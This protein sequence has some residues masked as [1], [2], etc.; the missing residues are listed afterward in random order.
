M[1]I[2]HRTATL[3]DAAALLNWR[4]NSSVREFSM[5]S[6]TIPMDEHLKWLTERLERV[7]LEPFLLFTKDDNLIGM[8]RLD[9]VS[10][11]NFKNEISV[12]VDSSQHG[13]R[14]GTKILKVTCDIF[15][16]LYPNKTIVAKVHR[17]NFVSQKLFARGGFRFISPEGEFLHFEKDLNQC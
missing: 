1:E 3:G 15:F 10:G 11:S 9:V 13:K 2:T 8:S 7:Q 5:N 4:N 6:K 14:I 17:S 12:L 16:D